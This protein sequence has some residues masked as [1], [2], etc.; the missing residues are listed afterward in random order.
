MIP[1]AKGSPSDGAAAAG[2]AQVAELTRIL[3]EDELFQYPEKDDVI[4]PVRA[5][6]ASCRARNGARAQRQRCAT[7]VVA[8][9]QRVVPTDLHSFSEDA[10]F[11]S[12]SSSS[13]ILVVHSVKP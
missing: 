9:R 6:P 11:S 1:R 2:R 3:E 4:G 5:P 7:T 12:S 8:A 10:P 13:C